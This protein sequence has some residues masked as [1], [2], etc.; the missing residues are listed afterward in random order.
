[1]KMKDEMYLYGFIVVASIVAL[2]L[3]VL[4]LTKKDKFGDRDSA[5]IYGSIGGEEEGVVCQPVNHS[6]SAACVK[7]EKDDP[8][9][10]SQRCSENLTCIKGSCVSG[11]EKKCGDANHHPASPDLP[12]YPNNPLYP[13][14]HARHHAHPHPTHIIPNSKKN[15]DKNEFLCDLLSDIIHADTLSKSSTFQS[16]CEPK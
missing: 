15:D 7:L 4:S 8:S 11:T 16:I 6:L 13:D 2:I 10:A 1:M 12:I 5:G 14:N 9:P 3:S